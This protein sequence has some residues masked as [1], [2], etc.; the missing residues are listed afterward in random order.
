M[1]FWSFILALSCLTACEPAY[2]ETGK[3]ETTDTGALKT[4]TTLLQEIKSSIEAACTTNSDCLAVAIGSR[5]CGGP[6]S[7]LPLSK[8]DGMNEISELVYEHTQA[9]KR[10]MANQ[11]GTCEALLPP[12]VTCVSNICKKQTTSSNV[13]AL[14]HF[15]GALTLAPKNIADAPSM[16]FKIT[17]SSSTL[18]VKSSNLDVATQAKLA[19]LR[20]ANGSVKV[21]VRIFARQ[22]TSGA[23]DFMYGD[24]TK[25]VSAVDLRAVVFN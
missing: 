20:Q 5:P 3:E 14:T 23:C 9:R 8:W 24:C 7:Y 17:N 4:S 12:T 2:K 10:E 13:G 15:V 1:K 19:S 6:E 22:Y 25:Q 18:Y 21:Q 16:T 11:V